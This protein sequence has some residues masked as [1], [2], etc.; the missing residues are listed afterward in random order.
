MR[1]M[2]ARRALHESGGRAAGAMRVGGGAGAVAGGGMGAG[3]VGCAEKKAA[4]EQAGEIKVAAAADL[5]R[6]FEEVGKAF[7]KKSG[8]KVTL[9]FGATGMLAKQIQEGAP[10]DLFAAANVSFV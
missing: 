6:A 5:S 1:R 10:F 8:K 7:E 2:S 4:D 9:S 3:A